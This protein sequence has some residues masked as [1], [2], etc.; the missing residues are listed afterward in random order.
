MNVAAIPVRELFRA[1]GR[2]MAARIADLAK[3]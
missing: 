3:G 2:M 1:L